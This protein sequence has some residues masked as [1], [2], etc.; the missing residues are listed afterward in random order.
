MGVRRGVGLWCVFSLVLP[1]LSCGQAAP[2]VSTPFEVRTKGAVAELGFYAPFKRR[3]LFYLDL[4]YGPGGAVEQERIRG[5]ALESTFDPAR[6]QKLW[7]TRPIPL[8]L[9]VSRL[10]FNG[11][12]TLVHEGEYAQHRLESH[13][14]GC[15]STIITSAELAPDYYRVRVEALEEVPALRGVPTRLQLR[16]PGHP[17]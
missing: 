7:R 14:H 11:V 5:V 6:Q 12:L 10:D 13:G 2:H 1:L 8:R 3:Y 17:K 15:I 4:C 9:T 16:V